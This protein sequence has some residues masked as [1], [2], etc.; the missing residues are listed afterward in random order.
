MAR[1]KSRKQRKQRSR[2]RKTYGGD[3]TQII[4]GIVNSRGKVGTN[5]AAASVAAKNAQTEAN[6]LVDEAAR[7]LTEAQGKLRDA[8]EN[9]DKIKQESENA[10][11]TAIQQAT[12]KAATEKKEGQDAA[13]A[14][15][16]AAR[17]TADEAIAA[18][19]AKALKTASDADAA[20][21]ATKLDA[22][23][24]AR[25][26]IETANN[27]LAT[28]QGAVE[29][30]FNKLQELA[31]AANDLSQQVALDAASAAST[32]FKKAVNEHRPPPTSSAGGGRKRTHKR[33]AHKTHK[34]S[35]RK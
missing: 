4:Q 35:H 21:A 26:M 10:I 3:F 11:R 32:S 19:D 30:A 31:K 33:R 34:R 8:Q 16:S 15:I 7:A 17:K 29:S 28:K 14:T 18:A 6:G 2:S 12:Q 5:A 24:R 22:E 13:D 20:A 27:D 9:A 23:N 25:E 1:F